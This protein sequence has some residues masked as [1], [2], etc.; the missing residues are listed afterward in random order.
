ML[1]LSSWLV[2]GIIYNISHCYLYKK[3][4]NDEFNF[5]I[6]LIL[7]CIII[8]I[9]NTVVFVNLDWLLNVVIKYIVMVF[10]IK[11]IYNDPIDKI[12]ISTLLIYILFSVGEMIFVII[13]IKLLNLDFDFFK[14]NYIRII[15]TNIAI[16]FFAYTIV[17]FKKIKKFMQEIV[18]WYINKSIINIIFISVLS[19]I[20]IFNFIYQNYYNPLYKQNGLL[21]YIFYVSILIII[22]WFLKEKTDNNRLTSDYDQLL[23]YVKTYEEVIEEKS[24][25][26][27]E[28]NNQLIL[29]REMLGNRNKKVKEYIDQILSIENEQSKG[30][31][32][33]K[34]KNIPNGGLKGLIHYKIVEMEKKKIKLYI[35]INENVNNKKTNKYLRDN[36]N[37]ISKIIGVYLD[38]AREAALKSK[39]KYIIIEA[40]CNK[41]K[42]N[43]SISNT[44]KGGINLSKIDN[45]GY[46]K[47]GKGRGYGLSLVRDIIS[48][49][50]DV[51]QYR[52]FN[53]IYFVQHI[54]LK[55]KK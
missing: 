49:R 28:Y 16:F 4:N 8:A 33:N 46:S 1:E 37:D 11:Y 9:I 27:H 14:F 23:D 30:N 48:K 34:I 47:K 54:C 19:I 20:L 29:I 26:Q 35:D 40:E 31:W 6:R 12:F 22:I 36:L 3:L 39:E 45:A 43:F 25:N 55:Y 50:D 17:A 24:K 44:Y 42:L 52:E 41:D 38:N 51:E 18:K 15:I 21:I 2:I 13:F 5:N 10:M 7:S 53:G 32:L